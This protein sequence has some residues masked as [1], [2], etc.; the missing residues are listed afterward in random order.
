VDIFDI[1]SWA[2]WAGAA[3]SLCIYVYAYILRP[4]GDRLM[5]TMGLFFTAVGLSQIPL[6]L[7]DGAQGAA[8]MNANFAIVS[9]LA[10]AAAQAIVAV[11]GRRSGERDADHTLTGDDA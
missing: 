5:S 11:R 4:R 1:L 10:A 2:A 7:R 3:L 9:F 6:F 8:F